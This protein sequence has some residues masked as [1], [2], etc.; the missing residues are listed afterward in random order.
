MGS[1]VLSMIIRRLFV[2]Y[3]ADFR[4]LEARAMASFPSYRNIYSVE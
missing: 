4:L 1:S 3:K 2:S